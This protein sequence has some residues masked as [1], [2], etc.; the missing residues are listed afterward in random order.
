MSDTTQRLCTNHNVSHFVRFW[1]IF[2]KVSFTRRVRIAG[3]RFWRAAC[4]SVNQ[5]CSKS[6]LFLL[7]VHSNFV[8]ILHHFWDIVRYWLK[9]ADWNLPHLYLASPLGVTTSEFRWD[10]WLQKTRVAYLRD[11]T[12]SRFGTVSGFDGRTDKHTMTAYTVLA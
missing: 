7:A 1:C 10:F 2:C 4:N 5:T 11:T 12:F 8:P 9:I 6:T 3:R